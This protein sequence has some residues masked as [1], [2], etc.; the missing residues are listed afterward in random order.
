MVV[1][2]AGA[3]SVFGELLIGANIIAWHSFGQDEGL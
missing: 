1:G 3:I 2:L